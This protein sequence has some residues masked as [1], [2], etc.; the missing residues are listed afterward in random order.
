MGK[1][2][3][4]LFDRNRKA[5]AS[6]A[7]LYSRNEQKP[8]TPDPA[9][10]GKLGGN[11]NVTACQA[12]G[13]YAWSLNNQAWYCDDCARRLNR[14]PSNYAYWKGRYGVSRFVFRPD[15]LTE[16]EIALLKAGRAYVP[17]VVE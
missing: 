10:K 2:S 3:N 15:T 11:C 1:Y 14:E 16:E 5:L 17:G 13:A 7:A 9:L 8:A 6:Q 4:G 12:P